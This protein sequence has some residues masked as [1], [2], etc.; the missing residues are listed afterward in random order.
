MQPLHFEVSDFDRFTL[1]DE[2]EIF[3]VVFQTVLIEFVGDHP[4]RKGGAVDRELQLFE[5]VGHRTDMVFVRMGDDDS[6]D[7]L[8]DR[9]QIAEIGDENIDAVHLF[10]REAHPDVD[11]DRA[12]FGFEYRHVAADLAEAAKR[13]KSDA[14]FV[15]D[16]DFGSGI[17]TLFVNGFVRRNRLIDIGIDAVAAALHVGGCF[18]MCLRIASTAAPSAALAAASPLTGAA[19]R[20]SRTV[21]TA[22]RGVAALRAGRGLFAVLLRIVTAFWPSGSAVLSILIVVLRSVAAAV[23]AVGSIPLIFLLFHQYHLLKFYIGGDR[24]M[25]PLHEDGRRDQD[26]ASQ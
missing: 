21:R 13:G 15:A 1:F 3:L 16:I 2:T 12:L 11:D 20:I 6:V 18:V 22:R 5:K 24:G 8:L 23:I 25:F 9:M 7:L 14:R 10:G 26:P 19:L 17:E 4:E